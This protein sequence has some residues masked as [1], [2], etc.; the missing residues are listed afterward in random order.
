MRSIPAKLGDAK[1]ERREELG[2]YKRK[3]GLEGGGKHMCRMGRQRLVHSINQ[4]CLGWEDGTE[5][6]PDKYFGVIGSP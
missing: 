2:M 3:K 1:T 6:R 5:N 4:I